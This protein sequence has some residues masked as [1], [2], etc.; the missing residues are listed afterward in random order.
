[1]TIT[2]TAHEHNCR[3][4]PQTLAYTDIQSSIKQPHYSTISDPKCKALITF[5]LGAE[6]DPD[7]RLAVH[8]G[9]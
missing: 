1:M 8:L 2:R 4:W 9:I 7:D 6:R 5:G 3:K